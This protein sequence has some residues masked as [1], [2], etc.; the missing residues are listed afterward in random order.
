MV[1]SRGIK[2]KHGGKMMA[3]EIIWEIWVDYDQSF[4]RKERRAYMDRLV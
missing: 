4:V 1:F 2:T 3:E